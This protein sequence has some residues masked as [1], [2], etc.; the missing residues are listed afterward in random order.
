MSSSPHGSPFPIS[1]IRIDP[2]L[3]GWAA[4]YASTESNVVIASLTERHRRG[5]MG[6]LLDGFEARV[7]DENDRPVPDGTPGELLLCAHEPF[8]MAVGYHDASGKTADAWRN[9][10]LHTGDRVIRDADG[11]FHFVDRLKDTIR[12]RGENISSYEIEQVLLMYPAV[13]MVAAFPVFSELAEDEVIVAVTLDGDERATAEELIA[14]CEGK[15]SY[16]SILRFID[17]VDD[18]PRADIGKI[19]KFKLRERGAPHRTWDR[20]QS[21]LALRR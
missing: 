2:P 3:G 8:A 15:M 21:S 18:L 6:V 4:R 9:L 1:A 5:T 19:Q 10:W 7:A 12:R 17:F 16:L 13:A 14:F 11:F 20:E